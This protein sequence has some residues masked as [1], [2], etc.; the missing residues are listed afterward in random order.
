MRYLFPLSL[1]LVLSIGC[2][3]C[4]AEGSP[5][6]RIRKDMNMD[7]PDTGASDSASDLEVVDMQ[8]TYEAC[9]EHLGEVEEA[10]Q[11]QKEA[12]AECRTTRK[13]FE[14]FEITTE[15][16][17]TPCEKGLTLKVL[18]HD[19]KR[20]W[21]YLSYMQGDKKYGTD[22]L[23]LKSQQPRKHRPDRVAAC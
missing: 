22:R 23:D 17:E 16:K 11:V 14:I 1:L 4:P 13:A 8:A 5:A 3:G 18:K 10:L 19:T 9:T 2:E 7:T 20:D 15:F 6:E 21:T 12:L